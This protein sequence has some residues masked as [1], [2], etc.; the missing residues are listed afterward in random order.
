MKKSS[1]WIVLAVAVSTVVLVGP[2]VAVNHLYGFEAGIDTTLFQVMFDTSLYDVDDFGGSIRIHKP[3]GGDYSLQMLHVRFRP[4]VFGDFD[5]S[6]DF[7]AAHIDRVDGRPGNQVQLN[8]TFGGQTISIVRSDEIV[9]GHNYH[10]WEEPPEVWRGEQ[11]DTLSK[12]TLRITRVGTTVTGYYRDTVIYS[13]DYNDA[14]VTFLSFSLQNNGTTD[15]TS[16]RFDDFHIV[17]DSLDMPTASG[18]AGRF[19]RPASIDISPNP[20]LDGT[21]IEYTLESGG[22]V[23]LSVYDVAGRRIAR[24]DTGRRDPG[25]YAVYWDGRDERGALVPSGVYFAALKVEGRIFTRKM[26][27]IR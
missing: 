4:V 14:E 2:A 5:V 19:S 1:Q 9:A 21:H 10:L 13:A 20:F 16:V 8:A 6:V 23:Q 22:A 3:V 15:T 7:R 25:G 26:T 17:A 11:P 18:V 24:L 12:G 27:L